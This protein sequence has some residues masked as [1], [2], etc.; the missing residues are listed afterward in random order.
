[1]SSGA[2]VQR[3]E[4]EARDRLAAVPTDLAS[5]LRPILPAVADEVIAVIRAEVD[6]YRRPF[7]GSFGRT[8][9]R[10]VELSLGEFV[11]LIEDP[12]RPAAGT[13]VIFELGRGEVRAGRTVDALQAAFRCGARV[14]WRRFGDTARD[15]GAQQDALIALGEAIFAYIHRLSALSVAGWAQEQSLRAGATQRARDALVRLAIA[16]PPAD[17]IDVEAAARELGWTPPGAV[18]VVVVPGGEGPGDLLRIDPQIAASVRDG[19]VV[20]LVPGSGTLERVAAALGDR[21]AAIGPTVAWEAV[22]RSHRRARAVLALQADGRLPGAAFPLRAADHLEALVVHADP[23]ASAELAD[24]VLAP[25][26]ALPAGR[27]GRHLETLRAWLDH[28]GHG[29]RMAEDLH[30]HPQTVRYRVA[31]LR[32]VLGSGLDDPDGRFRLEL[33]LR[34]R[35]LRH[36]G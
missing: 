21:P 34:R 8:V 7:G 24:Q 6:E 31:R 36:G 13:Q 3:E 28:R 19:A 16:D 9:R 10:G 11:G 35:G 22:A 1:M 29:P 18:A 20:G 4:R 33:A 26:D 12:E 27:R 30:L 23:G 5:V 2:G 15:H 32:E 14:A 25:L 17:E